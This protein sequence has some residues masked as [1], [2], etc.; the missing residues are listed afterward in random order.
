[1]RRGP[2]GQPLLAA[3]LLGTIS[4]S[5]P[6]LPLIWRRPRGEP[7][8]PADP[9]A[10][11]GGDGDADPM[12]ARYR[13]FLRA[14]GGLTVPTDPGACQPAAA[15]R[16][17][18]ATAPTALLPAEQE[19]LF[20]EDRLME[21]WTRG[22]RRWREAGDTDKPL[23]A[24]ESRALAGGAAPMVSG[25]GRPTAACSRSAAPGAGRA[26]RARRSAAGNGWGQRR[27]R[28]GAIS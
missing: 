7:A 25:G 19:P 20:A 12:L 8:P 23:L 13:Q 24:S 22:A 16:R 27:Q 18:R 15:V 21:Q 3:A 9:A 10:G 5:G 28:I 14:E 26:G 4:C 2:A 11:A 17:A 6:N 1:M